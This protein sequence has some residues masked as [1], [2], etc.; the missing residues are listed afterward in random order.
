MRLGWRSLLG[1]ALSV[2]LL[3]IT[4]RGVDLHEVWTILATSNLLLWVLCTVT[5]TAIFPLRARR[6]QAILAPSVGRLPVTPLWHATAIGMMVNNVFPARAGELARAY[7]I[8]KSRPE[9]R[10]TAA[11]A[12]LAVD[13]LFDGVVVLGMMVLATLDPR[14]PADA[15]IFGA[16]AWS[17]AATAALFLTAVLVVLYALALAPR[18]FIGMAERIVGVVAPKL[19]LKVRGLLEGFVSGLG[20]LSSPRLAA[21]VMWWT[22]LHW[23]TNAAAF[24]LGFLALGIEAP[25]SA[26]FFTQGLIAIGV[27]VPSSP[28]FFGVFEAAGTAGLGLYGVPAAS[29]VSWAIG[30]HI[31]SF[32]PI[33]IIGAWYFTRLG[34]HMKDVGGAAGERAP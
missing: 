2:F 25:V 17:I 8:T 33:T 22:V 28:G 3:W 6:W 29:A 27:A 30:F 24:Y 12:S 18:R 4:L 1:I 21:E 7:A 26:A 10:F 31:L 9:V 34:I 19:A 20:V 5:A 32:I 13:R 14:F 11:F 16:T 23:L 15:T